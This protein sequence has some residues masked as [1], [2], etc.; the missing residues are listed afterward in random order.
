M[1]FEHRA[2]CLCFDRCFLFYRHFWHEKT[3][4]ESIS[5]KLLDHIHTFSATFSSK[6]NTFGKCPTHRIYM[7]MK[8][9]RFVRGLE[10]AFVSS[11]SCHVRHGKIQALNFVTVRVRGDETERTETSI[12]I[13]VSTRMIY[14]FWRRR[15]RRR[16]SMAPIC[17]SPLT[18]S[19]STFLFFISRSVYAIKH[20]VLCTIFHVNAVANVIADPNTAAAVTMKYPY[21]LCNN[22]YF[23]GV[24]WIE[25]KYKLKH[26][27]SSFIFILLSQSHTLCMR[28]FHG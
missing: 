28:R 1:T 20:T 22:I 3:I 16:D 24:R 17:V 23:I 27:E 6:S 2:K 7:N 21:I 26:D 12:T 13:E 18:H 15:R 8:L 14:I 10:N 25:K 4:T 19:L 5:A 11:L 9:L